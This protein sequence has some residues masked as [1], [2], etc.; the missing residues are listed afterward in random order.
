M[1]LLNTKRTKI[2]NENVP[3]KY[4]FYSE[5]VLTAPTHQFC[6][7]VNIPFSVHSSQNNKGLD[8]ITTK[9]VSWGNLP[10]NNEIFSI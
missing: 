6:Y 1:C 9:A 7:P 5:V 4:F 8:G 10:L 3:P 2:L